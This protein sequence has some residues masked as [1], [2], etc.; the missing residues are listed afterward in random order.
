MFDLIIPRPK[1]RKMLSWAHRTARFRTKFQLWCEAFIGI[2]G[3]DWHIVMIRNGPNPPDYAL[4]C[5]TKQHAILFHLHHK[6]Y[7]VDSD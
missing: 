4:R 2:H 3:V 7:L 6:L 5:R 1:H